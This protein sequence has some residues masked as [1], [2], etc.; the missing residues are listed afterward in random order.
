LRQLLLTGLEDVVSFEKRVV[1][2]EQSGDGTVALR[3]VDGTTVAGDVV[4]GA[5]GSHSAIRR[6]LL[7]AARVVDSGVGGVAGK[8]YLDRR[9]RDWV[10][11]RLLS[12]M[13]MVL[14]VR[15]FA[16]FMAPFVRA[17]NRAESDV[18]LD[19]PEHLFWVLIGRAEAFG[20][21]SSDWHQQSSSALQNLAL[22]KAA[23]WH[24]LL[25]A[26]IAEAELS[27]VMAVPLS[28]AEPLP[29]WNPS[30]ITVLGD[31]IHTMTPLQGL[32]G[33][34][35][36]RDAAVL[37][38]QLVQA[39]RGATDLVSAIGGYEAEMRDYGFAAVQQSL[40]ISTSVASRQTVGRLAF[41]AVLGVAGA[42][43]GL[44]QR[45][46]G[47]SEPA[48]PAEPDALVAVARG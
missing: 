27:S 11:P 37:R 48:L 4:V 35:A 2:F 33:N 22:Q 12:Q 46:F 21:G 39:D 9:T 25:Q 7:P 47:R 31:A 44:S 8:V 32:G 5:D 42:V 40:Q 16:F 20:F 45:L 1:G 30:P 15:D 6:Q 18:A 29:A 19:M 24:P 10:G 43:P 14:G 13:T 26:L 23:R 34:T 17:S 28:T 38:H 41:R 3:F 36:L